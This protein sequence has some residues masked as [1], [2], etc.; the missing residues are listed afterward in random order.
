MNIHLENGI[1]R[2]SVFFY[3][4]VPM[5]FR[6]S[7]VDRIKE[8]TIRF[9]P[10]LRTFG[11]NV[12]IDWE[13]YAQACAAYQDLMNR[14]LLALGVL[15]FQA[16]GNLQIMRKQDPSCRSFMP[17]ALNRR[18]YFHRS[19]FEDAFSY[20]KFSTEIFARRSISVSPHELKAIQIVL[21][22]EVFN[23]NT[24]TAEV[25]VTNNFSLVG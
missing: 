16:D 5:A 23:P 18:L 8:L 7:S 14:I 20:I 11:T 15:T 10:F 9:A 21:P 13:F 19:R 3:E 24:V 22:G 25:I 1:P 17:R 6:H 2:A 4:E 12:E